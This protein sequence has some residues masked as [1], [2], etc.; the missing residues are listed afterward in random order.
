MHTPAMLYKS[1]RTIMSGVRVP[2][3]AWPAH[4]SSKVKAKDW[5]LI[6]LK[7]HDLKIEVIPTL[8]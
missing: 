5:K 7:L 6:Q 8:L 3:R 4:L 1:V 2:N